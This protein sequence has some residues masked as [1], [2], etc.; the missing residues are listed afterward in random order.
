MP[1]FM[2]DD[3]LPVNRKTKQLTAPALAGDLTGVA[4]LGMWSLAG[5]SVQAELSD[6]VVT[7]HDLIAIVY[8]V[9]LARQL[10]G[11]LVAAGLWHAPGHDCPRCEPVIDPLSWRFHDWWAMK[12]QRGDVVRETR[13]KAKEQQNVELVAAVWARD[14]IDPAKPGIAECRYCGKV[15]K[16]KDTRSD[17]D[18]RPQLDH[19]NPFIAAGPTNLVV[20]CGACNR[21]KARRTPED[22]GMSL[23]PEPRPLA[24]DAP[25]VPASPAQAPAAETTVS[26]DLAAAATSTTARAV[27]T[28]PETKPGRPA[29]HQ[30]VDQPSE[31]PLA[32]TREGAGAHTP[33]SGSGVGVGSGS[34]SGQGD[35]RSTTARQTKPRRRNRKRGRGNRTQPQTKPPAPTPAERPDPM[36]AGPAPR[37]PVVGTIGSPWH[38]YSG[39]RDPLGDENHCPMHHLPQPCRRCAND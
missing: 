37:V 22:A 34:G 3:Q 17:Y 11:L 29:D 35:P 9:N 7:I 15:V 26:P 24:A 4:A 31:S 14:C 23:R 1:Y 21:K 33:G 28:T 36:N 27:A 19:V 38:G 32:G 10:A 13:A 18:D 8:D 39:P 2:I 5:A 12:Y 6:G 16:R 20:A 30:V 25:T